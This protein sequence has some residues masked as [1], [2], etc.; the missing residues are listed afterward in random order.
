M[1][2]LSL[3]LVV[4]SLFLITVFI[5]NAATPIRVACVGNS[6]TYG[7][8]ID[9]REKNSYPAQ[10]QQLLGEEYEVRNFGK[11]GSTLLKKGHRPYTEQGEYE[12][13]LTWKPDQV[14]IHLGLN[15]TDPRNW[16]NYQDDFVS[17]YLSLIDSFREVNPNVRILICRLTPITPAHP[18]FKSGTRDWYAQIQKKIETIASISGCQLIDLQ[19][20][21]YCRP[22][23]L[24]AA[25]RKSVG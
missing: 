10:L 5:L 15:D 13:A 1:R 11:S 16:P 8:G 18:R 20:G 2:S 7:L 21:L 22:D 12:E 4:S 23:L 19:K 24:P 3:K 17:D 25:D 14:I 9:N 6:V